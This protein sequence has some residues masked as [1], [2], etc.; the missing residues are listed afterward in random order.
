MTANRIDGVASWSTSSG[1]DGTRTFHKDTEYDIHVIV[2]LND[3]LGAAFGS[4]TNSAPRTEIPQWFSGDNLGSD[5]QIKLY[6]KDDIP[7]TDPVAISFDGINFETI[8]P[9]NPILATKVLSPVNIV[10]ASNNILADWAFLAPQYKVQIIATDQA[11]VVA[12]WIA[13]A[14][15]DAA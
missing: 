11:C 4:A 7:I 8:T 14:N 15:V 12:C 5:D 13:Q 1:H 6:I 9:N 10:A 2:D 3:L